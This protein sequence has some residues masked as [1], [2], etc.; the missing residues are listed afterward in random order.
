M[1]DPALKDQVNTFI[2]AICDQPRPESMR[3]PDMELSRNEK[4]GIR[5]RHLGI[6]CTDCKDA[7]KLFS[8]KDVIQ[9]KEHHH[10]RI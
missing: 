8:R 2:C 5:V 9:P 1:T 7:R 10:E 4:H 3:G 6:R